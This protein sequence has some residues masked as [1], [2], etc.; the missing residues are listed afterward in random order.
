MT[1]HLI[2]AS[3]REDSTDPRLRNTSNDLGVRRG[4]SDPARMVS[5][6]LVLVAV[7]I[8][9]ALVVLWWLI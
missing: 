9:M 7:M 6:V 2:P 3:G 5:G 1:Y 8:V 4:E